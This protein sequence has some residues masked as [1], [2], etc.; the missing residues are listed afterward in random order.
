M[1]I[2][3]A[4]EHCGQKLTVSAS[5]AGQRGKCPKCRQPI[6]VPIPPEARTPTA[7]NERTGAKASVATEGPAAADAVS[8][9]AVLPTRPAPVS[10][11]P[12]APPSPSPL[13]EATADPPAT[14]SGKGLS[15][16]IASEPAP[17]NS[18]ITAPPV[19]PTAE[20]I[21]RAK[22]EPPP[23]VPPQVEAPPVPAN[24]AITSNSASDPELP[25]WIAES[26]REESPWIY[27]DASAP[28][29]AP[30]T[31]AKNIDETRV[32]LPR[33]VVFA[34]GVALGMVALVAFALGLLA[35]GGGRGTVDDSSTAAGP[36]TVSGIVEHIT[37]GGTKFPD[38]GAVVIFFPQDQ[39]PATEER[40]LPMGL[41]PEDPSPSAAVPGLQMLRLMGAAYTR[42][43]V[44]GQFRVTLPRGGSYYLLVVS[45][46]SARPK[47]RDIVRADLA[48][49]GRYV[50]STVDL[51]GDRRYRWRVEDIQRDAELRV[52]L[53]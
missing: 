38:E 48:L 32:S 51:I 13:L 9:A 15:S 2:G 22:A 49:I 50:T 39:R 26:P 10:P 1:S 41:R 53:E 46:H 34:Q 36:R 8:S 7:L 16:P 47:G 33:Y 37:S 31:A 44:T 5:R 45:H 25:T 11:A 12:V 21:E 52:L 23:V 4:C 3:F 40:A 42:T 24:E 30:S 43:D 17:A 18:N 19:S 20:Q 6:V 27:V 14:T 35:G 29:A 28:A